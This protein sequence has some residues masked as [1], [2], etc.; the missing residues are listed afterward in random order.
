MFLAKIENGIIAKIG[1]HYEFGGFCNPPLPEQLEE[2][3]FLPVITELEHD[4][5]TKKTAGCDPVIQDGKVFVVTIVDK[6][7]D[8]IAVDKIIALHSIRANRNSKLL[9]SD[10]TQLPDSTAN[11]AAWAT[12]RQALRD[13]PNTLTDPRDPVV[14][15]QAPQ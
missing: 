6:T 12:Y 3:G 7:D 5:R 10:W 15:P 2:R 14:W 8:D 4:T 1:D 13:L 9:A 11:K